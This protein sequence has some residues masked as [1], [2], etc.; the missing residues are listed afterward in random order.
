MATPGPD[1]ATG[2]GDGADQQDGSTLRTSE[3]AIM[4]ALAHPLRIEILDL[5]TDRGEATA[6]ELA[7]RLGQTVA[8][9]SFHL[10]ILA[11]GGFIERAEQRGREKPWKV[12]FE[13]RDMRPDPDD[14]ASIAHVSEL[15][16]MVVQHETAKTLSFLNEAPGTLTPAELWA[17]GITVSTSHFWATR[18]ELAEFNEELRAL[19]KRFDGRQDPARRPDGALRARMF[20]TVNPE[21]TDEMRTQAD[22]ADDDHQDGPAAV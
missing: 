3:P 22:A 6:S 11:G 12:A 7:Q 20:A 21:I 13:S 5:L 17:G 9:C 16:S 19:T 4:R 2:L 8:N 14:P 10:R 18:D 1:A 15:A